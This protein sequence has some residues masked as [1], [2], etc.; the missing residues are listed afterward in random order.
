MEEPRLRTRLEVTIAL[1]PASLQRSDQV[2]NPASPLSA[3]EVLVELGDWDDCP[4]NTPTTLISPE[5]PPNLSLPPPQTAA[6]SNPVDPQSPPPAS[7][8]PAPPRPL[9]TLAS[10]WLILPS[11]PPETIGHTAYPGSLICLVLPWSVIDLA[12]PAAQ[13]AFVL[14]PTSSAFVLMISVSSSISNIGG[15]IIFS[16]HQGVFY[17]QVVSYS[18]AP[19]TIDILAGLLLVSS[20]EYS[21]KRL[22]ESDRQLYKTQNLA[23]SK[24]RN[25]P[26]NLSNMPKEYVNLKEVFTT[27]LS[28]LTSTRTSF[29]WFTVAETA[30]ANLKSCFVS[31]HI[32]IA[33]DPT[34]LS[35]ATITSFTTL[36]SIT[37]H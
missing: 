14:G 34:A 19:L 25:E 10:P 4:A 3:E 18:M 9:D 12:V 30:F 28:A 33:T 26:V 7:A 32:L 22:A 35:M 2:L 11:A 5:F 15:Y 8:P 1:E 29:R 13:A 17:H 21:G 20:V 27:P 36:C 24:M 6:S 37:A 16:H 23:A 31:A